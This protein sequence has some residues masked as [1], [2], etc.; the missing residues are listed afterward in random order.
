MLNSFVKR[1]IEEHLSIIED[2]DWKD[3]FSN[4]YNFVEANDIWPDD[5]F[6]KFIDTL[7]TAGIHV[8]LNARHDVLY[9]KILY[10]MEELK[11]DKFNGVHHIGRFSLINRLASL[12][13]YTDSADVHKIMN[14]VAE[15]L[16]LRYTDYHGGGYTW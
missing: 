3:V 4:W 12:L 10:Y 5:V 1:F 16:G 8:D 13:G 9:D 14:E 15:S 7:D 6:V 11:K 2:N